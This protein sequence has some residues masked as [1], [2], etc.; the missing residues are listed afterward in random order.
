MSSIRYNGHIIEAYIIEARISDHFVNATQIGKA[1]GK[2]IDS[3]LST[4]KA[5]NFIQAVSASMKIPIGA[6]C[7]QVEP[8]RSNVG[9]LYV[10]KAIAY[11]IACHTNADFYIWFISKQDELFKHPVVSSREILELHADMY[12][13]TVDRDEKKEVLAKH[14]EYTHH[15]QTVKDRDEAYEELLEC[16]PRDSAEKI[17]VMFV[18]FIKAEGERYAA[19]EI[20]KKLKDWGIWHKAYQRRSQIT[21]KLAKMKPVDDAIWKKQI[22]KAASKYKDAF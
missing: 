12:Y 19:N 10:H 11:Y 4:S 18:K 15:K 16:S 2:D 5:Q 13:T 20:M 17:K 9:G 1:V 8:T 21:K 7:K 3:F 14:P 6:L 22:Q